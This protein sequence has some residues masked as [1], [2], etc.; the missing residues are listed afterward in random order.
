MAAFFLSAQHATLLLFDARL[1][2]WRL[3]MFLPF[4]FTIGAEVRW[5]PRLLPW[6][7]GVHG[8]LDVS[9]G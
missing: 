8:L 2:T 4:V 7:M 3:F 1:L 9:A 6:L 5:R